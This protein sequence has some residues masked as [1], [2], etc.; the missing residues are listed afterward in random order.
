M[1]CFAY[2][3]IC[4]LFCCLYL[5]GEKE[6]K[7]NILFIILIGVVKGRGGKKSQCQEKTNEVEERKG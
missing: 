5:F 2:I 4:I 6:G 3:T 7:R 1:S